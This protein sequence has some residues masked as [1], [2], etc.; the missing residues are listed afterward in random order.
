M[1]LQYRMELA[2][3][4]LLGLLDTEHDWMPTGGYE[5]AHD[6]GRWWDAVLRLEEAIGFVIPPELEAASLRNLQRF[7]DNPIGLLMHVSDIPSL[8]VIGKINLHNFRETLLAMGGL[9]R[10]RNSAWARSAGMKVVR[11]MDRYLQA[12]GRLDM[13]NL[14][15]EMSLQINPDLSQMQIVRNGWFDGTASSGRC[16]EALVWF[17][18]ETQDSTVFE[19]A[20]RIAEHHILHSARTDGKVHDGIIDPENLGHCHSYLGT[21][22]GLLLF[23]FLTHQQR[24]VDVVEATYRNGIRGRL[25]TES[26]WAPHDLGKTRFPNSNG[27]SLADPASAGD[28]AQIALWLAMR[29]GC[30]ELLDDVERI[31]RARLVP[32]QI[33]AQ[34]AALNLDRQFRSREMGAWGITTGSHGCKTAV[35]DVLAA[36]VHTL[37]DIHG[38]IVTRDEAGVRINLHMDRDTDDVSFT[39]KRGQHSVLEVRIK[40]PYNLSIRIPAWTTPSSVSLTVDGIPKQVIRAGSYCWIP[41]DSLVVGSIVRLSHDLP[42]RQSEE[43]MPSGRR[44]A[45][46][47][48]GDEVVGIDPQDTPLPFYSARNAK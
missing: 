48:R 47:W 11:A 1:N 26:G 30:A 27:D 25:V 9:A 12:D 19:V 15:D 6:L 14:S 4:A 37:C 31:V 29:A 16:L 45:F 33:T 24:F 13:S 43:I 22:R 18:L 2:G 7:T 34:D 10:R 44:Y 42:E 28:A 46:D 17:F 20:N 8:N 35:P 40:R 21:L 41:R 38:N 32:A 39:S 3:S 36:V 5:V 23:G